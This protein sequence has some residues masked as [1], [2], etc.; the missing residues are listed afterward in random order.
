MCKA[1]SPSIFGSDLFQKVSDRDDMDKIAKQTLSNGIAESKL[2]ILVS[3][4]NFYQ[5][6]DYLSPG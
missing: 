2:F 3:K 6:L 4:E 5:W 1:G